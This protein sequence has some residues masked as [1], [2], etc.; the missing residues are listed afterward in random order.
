MVIKWAF[1]ACSH[2]DPV[3]EETLRIKLSE[4]S[5]FPTNSSDEDSFSANRHPRVYRNWP[6]YHT[7]G[8]ALPL[9][10]Q[11]RLLIIVFLGLSKLFRSFFSVFEKNFPS[12][13]ATEKATESEPRNKAPIPSSTKTS[14]LRLTRRRLSKS[15]V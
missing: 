3:S 14:A 6:G 7:D 2:D 4:V 11:L 1:L 10:M 15:F 5:Q 13:R 8:Q 12:V 9:N